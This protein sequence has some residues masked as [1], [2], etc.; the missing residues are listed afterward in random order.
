MEAPMQNGNSHNNRPNNQE[1][2]SMTIKFD[3]DK[4]ISSVVLAELV[5]LLVFGWQLY[6]VKQELSSGISQAQNDRTIY[7]GPRKDAKEPPQDQ[8]DQVD[9]A[10]PVDIQVTSRDHIKGDEDAPITIV[11][12]SDFE[13]PF[14]GRVQPTLD[15]V[16]DEYGDDV[17]LVFRHFPLSFHARAQKAGE[18]SECAANQGK[19]WEYHDIL[20]ENQSSLS[21]GISQLKEWAGDLG[22]DQE[23]FD[24][25]LDNSDEAGTV[26][27]GLASGSQKGVTGT[28]GFFINGISLSGAQPFEAFSTIIDSELERLD[29]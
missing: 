14:C 5:L 16:L 23:R 22:L 12:Y 27:N 1:G 7:Q 6:T 3:R 24:E 20:F 28:P 19:F 29:S 9:L 10:G 11:E 25:C 15:R 21:G 2:K 17:R 26:K 18:A 4:F 8:P 13:C